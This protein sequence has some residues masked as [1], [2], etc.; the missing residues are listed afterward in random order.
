MSARTRMYVFLTEV[1]ELLEKYNKFWNKVSN[2]IQ[3]HFDSKP[4]VNEKYLKTKIKSYEGKVNTDFHDNGIPKES[5]HCICSSLI[6]I[7]SVF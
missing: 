4:A 7:D 6:L 1:N 2:G 3:K 5:S